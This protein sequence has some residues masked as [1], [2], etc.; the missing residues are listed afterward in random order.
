MLIFTRQEIE[1][2]RA[3]RNKSTAV[4]HAYIDSAAYRRKFDR[5]SDHLGLNRLLYQL[6]KEM[7][8]HRSGTLFEDMYW[9]DP[10]TI[11][12][13]AKETDSAAEGQ[14]VYSKRTREI[15]VQ[16]EN[17]ITIHS[18]PNSFPPSISDINS[19]YANKYL[20]GI[21]ACHDGRIYLYQSA[22][23]ISEDYYKLTV[24]EYLK[25]GYT[26][27]EAQRRTWEELKE[28]FDVLVKE[29]ADYDV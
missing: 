10:K 2:Q 28:K 25:R 3:G 9:I 6:A 21:I 14:I 16:N 27:D 20:A 23:E 4:D 24:A 11:K 12:V 26:E 5:I 22:E 7:L 15:V 13:V 18:H 29:V 8:K 17:L 1:E 19:N